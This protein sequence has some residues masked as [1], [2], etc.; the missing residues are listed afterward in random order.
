MKILIVDRDESILFLYKE[1][2]EADGHQVVGTL[3]GRA[4]PELIAKEKPGVVVVGSR[5]IDFD[6]LELMDLVKAAHPDLPMVLNTSLYELRVRA[7]EHGA[8]Y[9]ASRTSDL[10]ELRKIFKEIEQRIK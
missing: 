10:M 3:S 7:K 5:L 2:F 6:T 4:V 8:E 1:E 9:L